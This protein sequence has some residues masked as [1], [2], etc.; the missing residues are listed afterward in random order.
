MAPGATAR[1][2]RPRELPRAAA[3]AARRPGVLLLAPAQPTYKV[4]YC[5]HPATFPLDIDRSLWFSTKVTNAKDPC[6]T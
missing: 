5:G 4:Q 6:Q 3:G 2:R 1:V